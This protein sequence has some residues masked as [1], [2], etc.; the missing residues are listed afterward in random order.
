MIFA[1]CI[2][3]GC[4]LAQPDYTFQYPF[5]LSAEAGS[6]F[7]LLLHR[8][9]TSCRDYLLPPKVFSTGRLLPEVGNVT[10]RLLLLGSLDFY[11]A[12]LP[13]VNQHEYF[14][15]LGHAKQLDAGF[16]RYQIFF[17][18]PTGGRAYWGDH[19]FGQ[20][21]NA[22]RMFEI[23]GGI[24]ANSIMA[25]DISRKVLQK[26]KINFHESMLLLGAGSD[27]VTYLLF[28][29]ETSF[30]DLDQYLQLINQNRMPGENIEKSDLIWPATISFITNPFV[31]HAI[32]NLAWDYIP[33]G[34]T[35][36][37]LMLFNGNGRVSFIPYAEYALTPTGPVLSLNSYFISGDNQYKISVGHGFPW[38][39]RHAEVGISAYRI[40]ILPESLVT[41]L[42]IRGW[43]GDGFPMHDQRGNIIPSGKIG[44]LASM[45]FYFRIPVGSFKGR[46]PMV[47]AGVYVK[48]YG[49]SAGYMLQEG[50]GFK[51]GAGYFFVE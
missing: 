18:P 7:H 11:L 24:E 12:Y 46:V 29:E 13:V 48:T 26:E 49:Y 45:D 47:M 37:T 33:R 23:A 31:M 1:F 4:L 19:H 2:L 10:Y 50:T 21:T 16:T 42:D 28:E 25:G 22:E 38:N 43:V 17:F 51:I 6:A 3:P 39:I 34:R 5:S 40:H 8:E 20:P 27:L 41:D 15:H 9:I 44:G 35:V 32:Y 14:G 30:N 36:T